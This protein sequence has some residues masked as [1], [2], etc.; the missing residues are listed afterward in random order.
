MPTRI[1]STDDKIAIP[2]SEPSR[3]VSGKMNNR[4][5]TQSDGEPRQSSDQP[6][7]HIVRKLF[8]YDVAGA[9]ASELACELK[10]RFSADVYLHK[11][12]QLEVAKELLAA[13]YPDSQ[14][15]QQA[16]TRMVIK[17][18]R[19]QYGSYLKHLHH[20]RGPLD[21]KAI[22]QLKNHQ[23]SIVKIATDNGFRISKKA[24]KQAMVKRLGKSQWST[25]T[26]QFTLGS[27]PGQ[28]NARQNC[29]PAGKIGYELLSPAY[30]G[31]DIFPHSYKSKSVVAHSIRRK[32]HAT[33]MF[34]SE[35]NLNLATGTE[36]LTI[37][38]HGINSAYGLKKNDIRAGAAVSRATE[39]ITAALAVQPDKFARALNGER[40][41]LTVTS[42]SLLTPDSFRKVVKPLGDEKAMLEDQQNAFAALRNQSPL[43]LTVKDKNG[44]HKSIAVDLK[45]VPFNF[46]VNKFAVGN[47]G[48]ESLGGWKTSDALNRTG[49]EQLV[50]DPG[51]EN[52][53]AGIVGQWLQEH[54]NDHNA[55]LV[56]TLARQIKE[57][58]NAGGHHSLSGGAYK[59]PARII[60][61]SSLIG[62][63]PCTNCKSGK[64]RTSMAVAAAEA[65]FTYWQMNHTVP[66]WRT[67]ETAE[68]ELVRE[69]CL[70]GGH[71]EIQRLNT[72][73][74]G[75]KIQPEILRAYGM[76]AEDIVLIRGLSDSVS[77]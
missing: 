24:F 31:H 43:T 63:V 19:M 9:E 3:P 45:L 5:V 32:N 66:D 15:L 71:H 51:S 12:M 10:K 37:V 47:N 22:K 25:I 69:L 46:G 68:S 33:N 26:S 60:V 6:G 35:F 40:V 48:L 42:S 11:K 34:V 75:F 49:I 41:S 14:W 13:R 30:Q 74:S 20:E 1:R 28:V 76:S 4:V 50:G 67:L 73:V 39:V 62:A 56:R 38:R 77:S 36:K 57:I 18:Q 29:I 64:D 7:K 59:L 8:D 72:G 58:F 61:L 53:V 21:K 65:L 2:E 23:E 70:R 55:I 54:S 17:S 16:L 27:G 52:S 44:E